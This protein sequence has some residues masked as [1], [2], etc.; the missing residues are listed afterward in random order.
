[1]NTNIE[2][3]ELLV[4]KFEELDRK[5]AVMSSIAWT[6]AMSLGQSI[7][8][9]E[10][11]F[12]EDDPTYGGWTYDRKVEATERLDRRIADYVSLIGWAAAQ[13]NGE[14]T[15]DGQAVYDRVSSSQA[16]DTPANTEDVGLLAKEM[17]LTEAEIQQMLN[18]NS[19]RQKA[20]QLVQ[21][22]AAKNFKDRI[23]TAV[24]LALK[25]SESFEVID[26]Y[27][28]IRIVNRLADKAA[29]YAFRA[30]AD[31][32]R[33]RRAKRRNDLNA[34]ARMFRDLETQ[35]DKL[36]TTLEREAENITEESPIE[37]MTKLF[38]S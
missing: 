34:Q 13:T 18:Y 9:Q 23:I 20:E 24:D 36:L 14:Y 33:Q 35:C 6:F 26:A 8:R 38:A 27:D 28:A 22:E 30:G 21:S 25:S 15:P 11:V 1:M 10:R 37:K 4:T 5:S 32:C 19:E 17:G 7:V 29:D 3:I 16:P 12:M 2:A 31:A